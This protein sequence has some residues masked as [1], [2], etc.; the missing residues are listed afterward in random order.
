MRGLTP[1]RRESSI[2]GAYPRGFRLSRFGR[3]ADRNRLGGAIQKHSPYH[4]AV[5]RATRHDRSPHDV[6]AWRCR[7]G[8]ELLIR[9]GNRSPPV[10]G[11]MLYGI[12][13]RWPHGRYRPVCAV[14]GKVARRVFARCRP[15][16][17]WGLEAALWG[18]KLCMRRRV[19]KP[20]EL[21]RQNMRSSCGGR[22]YIIAAHLNRSPV[23]HGSASRIRGPVMPTP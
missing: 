3:T 17:M 23:I 4:T 10:P 6:S 19:G 22:C 1:A 8:W 9:L 2:V 20:G 21:A 15:K 7:A 18:K 13:T 12:S 11:N 14:C 16:V 5:S